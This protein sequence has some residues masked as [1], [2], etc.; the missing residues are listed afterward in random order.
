MRLRF[1][2]CKQVV[3]LYVQSCAAHHYRSKK[4]RDKRQTRSI[5]FYRLST[6]RANLRTTSLVLFC[7]E[8]PR[9][10]QTG[11]QKITLRKGSGIAQHIHMHYEAKLDDVCKLQKIT[12][13]DEVMP[14]D[15]K[16]KHNRNVP[17]RHL[18]SKMLSIFGSSTNGN[19][20]IFKSQAQL[21]KIN[22]VKPR[23]TQNAGRFSPNDNDPECFHRAISKIL[24]IAQFFGILPVTGIRASSARRF[25]FKP[26][27]PRV[28]Y[29]Y[30][31]LMAI[32]VMTSISVLHLLKTLNANSFST[33]GGIAD[34]TAG[35]I[36][37]GNSLFGNIMFLRLCPRWISIQYDW[38]AMERL[39]DNH[40]GIA[41]CKRP[42]LRW[43]FNLIAGII[44]GLALIEHI[45]SM[46]NNTTVEVFDRNHSFEDFLISYTNKSHSFI[47]KNV[48]YNFTLGLFI[49][50]VSKISTFTW[51]FTD[52]FI[53]LISVGLTERYKCLNERV[54]RVSAAQLSSTDWQELR[55]SYAVL[56]ALVKKVDN[57]ISG[58]V[59]LSFGNNIYFICLQLLNGLTPSH[60]GN[61]I[62]NSIYFFGSFI[63]LIGRTAAVTLLCARINDQCKVILPT[64]YNCPTMNYNLEA[65]RLHQQIT[66]DDV[67]LTGHRF[68][69]I[70]RNFM[71]AVAGAIV[72]YEVVLL[73]FNVALRRDD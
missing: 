21:S 40:V 26:L 71:L 9:R 65:Q 50:I 31:I 8:I 12:I 7:D 57:K 28:I 73:Q 13:C 33:N 16:Y 46:V 45:L 48:S 29:C 36:F 49:F 42:A 58:I 10:S 3:R 52:L 62:V 30:V 37:Y 27:S 32:I 20:R 4:R 63:F 56:S 6:G 11:L 70:T 14:V 55:E 69:S 47:V 2:W 64:L 68:F 59:L 44:L 34:A 61:N 17:K 39:L 35:A 25:V 38:R 18:G 15:A 51:N 24:M 43:R 60:T 72:T 41:K 66:T 19:S 53:M 23:P 54:T 67:A 1:Y 22:V 5:R